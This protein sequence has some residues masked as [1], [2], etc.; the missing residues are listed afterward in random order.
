MA[1]AQNDHLVEDH[2]QLTIYRETTAND[3]RR[4]KS[5]SRVW[6]KVIWF[7]KR[8][9][10]VKDKDN[11]N[12]SDTFF[13]S[14]TLENKQSYEESLECS[15]DK[16]K[17][18]VRKSRSFKY[19]KRRKDRR[20]GDEQSSG[21]V[22][23][24]V[25]MP[26]CGTATG[27]FHDFE[28]ERK[29]PR[30]ERVKGTRSNILLSEMARGMNPTQRKAKENVK[31]VFS[32]PIN[33]L[34]LNER[35]D[36]NPCISPTFHQVRRCVSLSGPCLHNSWPRN[37]RS[38]LDNI[39]CCDPSS[40]PFKQKRLSKIKKRATFSGFDSSRVNVQTHSMLPTEV[41]SAPHLPS[42][43]LS[44][45]KNQ[46]GLTIGAIHFYKSPA[47]YQNE[48]SRQKCLKEKMLEKR[49]DSVIGV[50]A[51]AI[52]PFLEIPSHNDKGVETAPTIAVQEHGS[53][54]FD[55]LAQ[56]PG[57]HKPSNGRN[58]SICIVDSACDAASLGVDAEIDTN[59]CF[60][61][62][63]KS[64][65]GRNS[66]I[67]AF[68]LEGECSS[69]CIA[70]GPDTLE[71]DLP[72]E[73]AIILSCK[74]ETKGLNSSQDRSLSSGMSCPD[75]PS[76]TVCRKCLHNQFGCVCSKSKDLTEKGPKVP[77]FKMEQSSLDS[78]HVLFD[79]QI[80]F[81]R[82]LS[83]RE[84]KNTVSSS[85]EEGTHK[86]MPSSVQSAD[87]VERDDVTH[88][89]R[90]V[91]SDPQ[92]LQETGILW[93]LKPAVD[94]VQF[95]KN[96]EAML[97][98]FREFNDEQKNMLIR[99]LLEECELPQM[100]MLSVAMEPIL[101]KTC[102]PN[103]Q[104][105]LAWLPLNVSSYILSFLDCVTLCRC[106][107]VN[108]TWNNLASN[109]LLWQNLCGQLDWQLSRIGEEKERKQYTL[110]DGTVQWKKI[111]ASRFLLHQNWLKGKCNVRT[112]EGH[113]QGIS[114][115][116]FDDTRIAS[117]SYDKTI[118]VWDIKSDESD[119]VLTLAGHSG[120]V[121]CLNLNGNRLVSGSV[122][123]SIKV[124]DLS[125]KSYWS[126]ASCKVT[127]IG[128]MHTVR[129]L[130]VDDEKVVSGSYDKT[131]KVWDI[132]TG[133]CKLTL[134]GHN[135]AVLCVQFDDRKIVS[136][137]YD[138]TIKV[139]SLS[140]GSCLMT[141]TGHHD[142]VTCLNLTFDSRKVISGSLDHNL[143]FWDLLNGKC[144][145]TLD[146]IRSEGHTGVIRCLQTDSWR[147]VSAGD[148]KTLKMWSLESG[149]RLLTLRCH[150][151]GVTC[152]Q[153]N[154]FS[155]VSGSYDKTVKL[156]DF[157][158]SHE[159]LTPG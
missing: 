23:E 91:C 56:V 51:N 113:T 112:L 122:D 47:A 80:P 146:W 54:S 77:D 118:R 110:R 45:I 49:V 81:D 29:T 30:Y 17:N 53:F 109:S 37:K 43:R 75:L 93:S 71:D 130:Q 19:L 108:R 152:L 27:T 153:F 57:K 99:R 46:N 115:V 117:G 78:M 86:S 58:G 72:K 44:Q 136:G 62:S 79:A 145:G 9:K 33:D 60:S 42:N 64:G 10:G 137:S 2:G 73:K 52:V 128:H 21:A 55:T 7:T 41:Q 92:A 127:M 59:S 50:K 38:H 4:S 105:M 74:T 94:G 131:L 126:G 39:S 135:A 36:V 133:D 121:R 11:K 147:I 22:A 154:D 35:T 141:L 125:F 31:R 63:V 68:L 20:F 155:I 18:K 88:Q 114:C 65:G 8:A 40:P 157:T 48:Q 70:A 90:G 106:S 139:W 28:S 144:I 14:P 148:D 61:L 85:T 97:Q 156:W 138:K 87:A 123:R 158:P 84:K 96:T 111:F 83:H 124:W 100:H 102:P 25:S 151:D 67:S 69:S 16:P 12:S 82:E 76:H 24:E 142:A 120:T 107:Q 134:R 95:K 132:R 129:C 1:L 103:C 101:H 15:V 149:Q 26:D 159:F 98:W 13:S 5:R 32:L 6:E 119:V 3:R 116:Q 140:E 89:F 34:A 104:D 150:T 66:T 143:K